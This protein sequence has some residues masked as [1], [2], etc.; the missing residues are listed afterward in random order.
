MDTTGLAD[1][2]DSASSQGLRSSLFWIP[3]RIDN[4]TGGQVWTPRGR[5]GATGGSA[6][7]AFLS[8]NVVF[9]LSTGAASISSCRPVGPS[10]AMVARFAF[11]KRVA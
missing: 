1:H 3:R 6:L 4:S 11:R 2:V 5:V 7:D 9:A 10:P 8:D